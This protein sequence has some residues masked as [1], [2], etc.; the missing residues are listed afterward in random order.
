MKK[1][2]TGIAAGLMILGIA[3]V[4]QSTT[5]IFSYN[6]AIFG[7]SDYGSGSLVA[8]Y[9]GDGEYD[10]TGGTVTDSK[11]GTINLFVNPNPMRISYSPDGLFY[12]DNVLYANAGQYLDIGG[13]LFVNQNGQ[14]L[15]LWGNG[16]DQPYSAFFAL[17]GSQGNSYESSLSDMSLTYV[18]FTIDPS[19]VPESATLPLFGAGLIC[20]AG[21]VRRKQT[22]I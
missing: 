20:L 19:P 8:T 3:G 17:D 4:A 6:G 18:N 13:L 16:I 11:Y 21:M 2:I 9:V 5:F 22:L 14:E 12:Y 7:N 15:N 1:Y 10:V